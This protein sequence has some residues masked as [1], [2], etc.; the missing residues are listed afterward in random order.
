MTDIRVGMTDV[1][2]GKTDIRVGMTDIRSGKT[3]NR[4]GMTPAIP[5]VKCII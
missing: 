3:D 1:R 5:Q 2:S 4:V